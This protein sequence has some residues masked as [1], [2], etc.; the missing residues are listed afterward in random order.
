M[1]PPPAQG[2]Q[3]SLATASGLL[4]KQLIT[5][6]I[7]TEHKSEDP[8][9]I[10]ICWDCSLCSYSCLT[11]ENTC[12]TVVPPPPKQSTLK[13][14]RFNIL[15]VSINTLC[16]TCLLLTAPFTSPRKTVQLIPHADMLKCNISWLFSSMVSVWSCSVWILETS[17]VWGVYVHMS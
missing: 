1:E 10:H 13:Q 16:H 6:S 9:L 17:T 8:T 7:L 2:K 4:L 11:T 15:G 5:F 12:N 3:I 14:R